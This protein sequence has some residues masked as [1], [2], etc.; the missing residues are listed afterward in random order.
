[1]IWPTKPLPRGEFIALMAMCTA[2]VA[3]S[4]DAMLPALPQI[5]EELTPD[6]P[7]RAQLILTSFV[8]GMGMG[9][10][11][12]GPLSDRFGRKPVMVGGVILYI[13]AAAAAW[14]S[15]SLEAMLVARVIQGLGAS[16]P[17]VVALAMVRDRY[18]GTDMARTMSFVMMIFTLVPALAPTLGA[19]IIVPFGWRAV[20]VAFVV[21]AGVVTT[22]LLLRQPETLPVASRRP[23]NPANQWRAA[24]EMF[25]NP[26][27]RLSIMI[28]TLSFGTLFS[29][30]SSTQQLFDVTYGRGETFHF[31][32]GGIALVAAS[33]SFINARYVVVVGMRGM[34]RMSFL[35]LIVISAIMALAVVLPLPLEVEFAVFVMWTTGAFFSAGMT[36][37]NLTTLGMEPMGHM[38]GMAASIMAAISTIGAVLIA[39]PVG[40]AYDGTPLPMALASLVCV[41]LAF[42]LTL[43]I[44][45]PGEPGAVKVTA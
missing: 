25:A 7:N 34:I 3:F 22:W 16:G 41:S 45:R 37:G 33:A 31:W 10:F 42:W 30:L 11:V 35:M 13:L 36:I 9:T 28:Q 32:F 43:K 18:S 8:L 19:A 39:A 2:T 15:Q 1:M 26:T 29:S 27:A 44:V 23:L 38:A 17:R 24:R 14:A 40:L 12:A 6:A 21:F 20:F 5:I 4:I